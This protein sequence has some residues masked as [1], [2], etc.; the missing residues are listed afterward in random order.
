MLKSEFVI[1]N[2][3]AYFTFA[4]FAQ[5]SETAI[6]SEVDVHPSAPNSIME[7]RI[8]SGHWRYELRNATLVDLIRTAWKVDA[9]NVT[10]ARIGW[11]QI[12]ST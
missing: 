10:G 2:F 11:T 9:D 6:L 12:A 3:I 7:M 4:V 5:S 1:L 8:R